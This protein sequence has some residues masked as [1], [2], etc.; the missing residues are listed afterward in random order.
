[1]IQFIPKSYR[2]KVRHKGYP[3]QIATVGATGITTE[4]NWKF[5]HI[6]IRFSGSVPVE[7]LLTV[8][9]AGD[10]FRF[11]YSII[12]SASRLKNTKYNILCN[13]MYMYTR[14][15]IR[16][17]PEFRPGLVV[18][19]CLVFQLP[20]PTRW[21]KSRN[22]PGPLAMQG[23]RVNIKIRYDAWKFWFFKHC[24]V[25]FSC[26]ALNWKM[27]LLCCLVFFLNIVFSQ[28]SLLWDVRHGILPVHM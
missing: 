2:H 21:C 18:Y 28:K 19:P 6:S 27:F 7:I 3:D 10:V 1:M 11:L 25:F 14:T 9:W 5:V 16:V 24:L 17:Q 15:S 13:T 22:W 8:K 26:G 20:G 12:F 23:R 4:N